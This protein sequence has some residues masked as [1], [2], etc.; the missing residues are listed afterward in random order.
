MARTPESARG[1]ESGGRSRAQD[2]RDLRQAARH[3]L[4][5]VLLEALRR[6]RP[7]PLAERRLC[8]PRR[9]GPARPSRKAKRTE[10]RSQRR[11]ALLV[12][13]KRA[14][15]GLGEAV[16]GGHVDEQRQRAPGGDERQRNDEGV[17]EDDGAERGGERRNWRENSI[18]LRDGRR[19]RRAAAS[20]R[21]E[22]EERPDRPLPLRRL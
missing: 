13:G 12:G 18:S 8:R 10:A 4:R 21:R 1:G 11:A 16:G 22:N 7:P 2:L 5:S 15:V 3:A 19:S 6:R 14:A 9:R 17:A 20:R